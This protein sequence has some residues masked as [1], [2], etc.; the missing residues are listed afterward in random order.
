MKILDA[1]KHVFHRLTT[2]DRHYYSFYLT[3]K[4]S[5][6]IHTL[7]PYTW[8][9]DK[10]WLLYCFYDFFGYKLN[11][12]HPETYNEKLQWSKLYDRN[13]LYTTISDK[14]ACRGYV[15]EKIGPQHVKPLLSVCG[16]IDEIDWSSLPDRFV[17]KAN[18]GSG[19]NI[20]CDDKSSFDVNDARKNLREWLN[21]NFYRRF[22]EWQYKD[23]SPKILIEPYLEGDPDL[24]LIEYQFYC[25]DGKLEFI[26]ID[27][28]SNANHSRLFVDRNWE[29]APFVIKRLPIFTGH[30]PKPVNLDEY[31]HS[32]ETLTQ[33]MPFCRVDAYIYDDRF[34]ISEM[35]LTPG[36]G[37]VTFEPKTY[38]TY[39]GKLIRLRSSPHHA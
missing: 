4:R 32:V 30:I 28:D 37:F 33:G 29:L 6:L 22:R 7:A 8:I 11:L 2:S 35:T 24:G 13:A 38:D 14:Y 17:I 18:H 20:F 9:D 15:E 39:F 31:I 23:I 5:E 12:K 16:N 34:L 1:G 27:V 36:A 21:T 10:Y 3:K 19:W 26:Q 25:F